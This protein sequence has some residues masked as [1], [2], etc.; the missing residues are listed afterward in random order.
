MCYVNSWWP[1]AVFIAFFGMRRG[2]G[3]RLLRSGVFQPRGR[4]DV[5]HGDARLALGRT[6]R[7]ALQPDLLGLRFDSRAVKVIASLIGIVSVFP[8]VVLGMQALGKVSR[9][10][11]VAGG[12]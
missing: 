11:A 10:P 5:L 6:L 8:W 12:P 9:S 7:L 2:R 1:G 3:V 4:D